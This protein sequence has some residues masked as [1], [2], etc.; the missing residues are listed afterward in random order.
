MSVRPRLTRVLALRD[1][2]AEAFPVRTWLH[3]TRNN[4]FLLSAGM[5]YY[6]LF[7]LFAL[8]YVIFAAVGIWLGGNAAAVDALIDLVNT[9]TPGLISENGI[10]TPEQ[11]YG[12][13]RGSTGVLGL[14]GAVAIAVGVWTAIGAVTFARRA[15]RD[16]FGLPFDSRGYLLLKLRDFVGAALF[17]GTLIL[18]AVISTLGV[19]ALSQMFTLTGWS[20]RVWQFTLAVRLLSILVIF[21]VN[22]VALAALVRFLTGTSIPWRSIGPG[23]LLGGGALV[24]LQLALG[25]LLAFVPSNPLLATFAVIIGLLLWCRWVSIVVLA[26]ASWIAVTAEDQDHP[27]TEDDAFA[28]RL[29]ELDALVL[30]ARVRLARMSRLAA[31]APWHRRRRARREVAQ[32]RAELAQATHAR[33]ELEARREAEPASRRRWWRM[34]E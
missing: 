9:Y 6:V 4:G 29:A 3:F 22:T 8:L 14:T 16:I 18:G 34:L 15:V 23:A 7:A 2:A 1:R 30:A 32:A 21:A 17:G 5:S 24:V 13:A 33:E 25:L 11:V 12:I 31:A 28:A 27:L 20:T 19:W 26:A 10:F